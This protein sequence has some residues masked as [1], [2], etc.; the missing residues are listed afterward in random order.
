MPEKLV[1]VPISYPL[2]SASVGTLRRAVEET[3]SLEDGH[4]YVLHVNLLHRSEDVDREDLRRAVERELGPLDNVSYHVRDAFL[5]EEAILYEAVQNDAD[6]VVIGKDRRARWRQMLS[7]R[8]DLG[9]DL[10]EFLEEHL[11]AELIVV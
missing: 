9:V 11:H 8:L 10:G 3:D 1:L 6:Y 5:H 2:Q 7:K 4:L